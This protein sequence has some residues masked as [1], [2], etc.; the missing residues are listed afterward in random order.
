M[1]HMTFR[2]TTGPMG[3]AAMFVLAAMFAATPASAQQCGGNFNAWLAGVKQEAAA[4][5]V[6]KRA[7]GVLSQVGRDSRVISRD[8]KQ[9]VFAQ[10]FRQFSGRMVSQ[11]RLDHGARNLK[12]HARIFAAV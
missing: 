3:A 1:Q 11:N 4:S 7:L 10:T 12:K 9:G 6:S 5:G 8:R 2:T